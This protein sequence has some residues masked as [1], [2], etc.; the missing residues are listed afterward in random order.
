MSDGRWG[1]VEEAREFLVAIEAG[2]RVAVSYH[3]DADGSS[4]AALAVRYLER[5]GRAATA[6]APGKGED[7]HAAAHVARLLEVQPAALIVLDQGSR[8]RA[9][10]PGVPT[11]VVDHHDPPPEG[12][13]VEVY[14]SGLADD[15]VPTTSIMTWRLLAPMTALDD[16][17]WL[18]AVGALGD[19]GSGARYPEVAEAAKRYGRKNLTEVVALV[20]AAKRGSAHDTET[21]LAALLAADAPA[22][23][24]EGRVPQH[25]RLAG[26]RAEVQAERARCLRTAPRFAGDWALLRFA[27][28]CQVHGLVAAAWVSRLPGSIVMAANEGYTPGNVHFSLRTRRPGEN[29]LERLRAYRDALGLPELGQGHAQA[30]GAILP[31]AQFERLLEAIG[32]EKQEQ[33][34]R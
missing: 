12:V 17:L 14:L 16:S 23:I 21:S 19:L 29:L 4:A 3:G 33:P 28:P 5:T 27:S 9:P 7:V 20:N 8:P 24:A 26:Y 6:I 11:L 30:T 13:P 25:P 32:F 22:E 1:T 34:H 10:L 2:E 31:K 15:P 18:A